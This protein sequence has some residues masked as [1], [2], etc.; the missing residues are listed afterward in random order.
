MRRIQ[1]RQVRKPRGLGQ[2]PAVNLP[3]CSSVDAAQTV[4]QGVLIA[5][6]GIATL[7]GVVGAI[8]SDQYREQFAIAAGAGLV[9]SFIGGIWAASSFASE[10]ASGPQCTGPGLAWLGEA[11]V[12][13]NQNTP[14]GTQASGF[15]DPNTPVVTTAGA[16]IAAPAS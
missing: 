14:A 13:P 16:P 11:S 15:L 5:G 3:S 8:F 12:N 1:A 7:V 4:P 2:T 6:G 10:I 9:A